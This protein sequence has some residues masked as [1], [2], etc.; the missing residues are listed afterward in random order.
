[1]TKEEKSLRRS[2]KA[3]RVAYSISDT[4]GKTGKLIV[5]AGVILLSIGAFG[6]IVADICQCVVEAKKRKI[7]ENRIK[8]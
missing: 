5:T 3:G 1:M 7:V 8:K 6:A 4:C 2:L